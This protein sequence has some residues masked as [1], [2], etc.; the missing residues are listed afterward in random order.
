MEIVSCLSRSKT[1]TALVACPKCKT[2]LKLNS[3]PT[4]AKKIQCPKCEA[5]FMVSGEVNRLDSQTFG[6][7]EG[8]VPQKNDA[9]DRRT[10][11]HPARANGSALRPRYCFCSAVGRP[12]TC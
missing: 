10:F 7:D 11:Q 1:M 2:R 9:A 6:A 3:L 5:Y 12:L 8:R 4:E